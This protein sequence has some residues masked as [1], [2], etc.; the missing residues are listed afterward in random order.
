MRQDKD[1]TKED[2]EVAGL[3]AL[4]KMIREHQ[5]MVYSLAYH[6]LHDTGEAEE[7]TQD[8][9]L[10]LSRNGCQFQ[11][12]QH[13]VFWLRKVTSNLCIDWIRRRKSGPYVNL[14]DMARI[15]ISDGEDDL[16]QSRR[17]QRL[18]TTLPEKQ[19]LIITLRF[20]EDLEPREIAEI[21]EVPVNTVKS[22]LQRAI[23]ILREKLQVLEKTAV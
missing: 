17:L 22:Q 6:F 12:P 19:R 11:S 8:V 3:L 16:F 14:E 21:L 9:F 1:E 10:K 13:L 4:E 7:L 5:A 20:Q 2:Q 23:A 18:I 15:E